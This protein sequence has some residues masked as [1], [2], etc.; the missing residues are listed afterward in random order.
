MGGLL[1]Q[2]LLSSTLG[3]MSTLD[4][5]GNFLWLN[6]DKLSEGF[7]SK[8]ITTNNPSHETVTFFLAH[9]LLSYRNI[10]ANLQLSKV[11]EEMF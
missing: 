5:K 11:L 2:R 4:V 1:K 3:L 8:T 10:A 9:T 6:P 7:V